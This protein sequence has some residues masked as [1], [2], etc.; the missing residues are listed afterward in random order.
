M[1]QIAQHKLTLFAV[2]VISYV[3][4]GIVPAFFAA[5]KFFGYNP[6]ALLMAFFTL[7]FV[8]WDPT[9]FTELLQYLR[10]YT[11]FRSFERWSTYVYSFVPSPI[12][13]YFRVDDERRFL[14]QFIGVF[15]LAQVVLHTF[16][17]VRCVT[18]GSAHLLVLEGSMRVFSPFHWPVEVWGYYHHDNDVLQKKFP[19]LKD[20][21]DPDSII[22]MRSDS[23]KTGLMHLNWGMEPNKPTEGDGIRVEAHCHF[24]TLLLVGF[25][26]VLISRGFKALWEPTLY[27]PTQFKHPIVSLLSS[28]MVGMCISRWLFEAYTMRREVPL[29]FTCW[30][31]FCPDIVRDDTIENIMWVLFSPYVIAMV[32]HWRLWPTLLRVEKMIKEWMEKMEA[33]KNLD[34]AAA[35]V[36]TNEIIE[37]KARAKKRGQAAGPA[38]G[39]QNPNVPP[40]PPQLVPLQY[41]A[42]NLALNQQQQQQMQL[43]FA[44]QNLMLMQQFGVAQPPVV[45]AQPVAQAQPMPQPV[46]QAQPMLPPVVQAQPQPVA[47]AQPQPQPQAPVAA[48]PRSRGSKR[49]ADT[50]AS[51]SRRSRLRSNQ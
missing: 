27:I 33:Q 31:T 36:R 25:F 34:Q 11:H 4:F 43:Q 18:T 17:G 48:A 12:A 35:T 29:P 37:E 13:Y 50:G 16:T 10:L 42:V 2:K 21:I 1:E 39:N 24:K 26:T 22:P 9:W 23:G 28:M 47:Q 49:P 40:M 8:C 19:P 32:V 14:H 41:A 45:Q 6:A 46:A 51:W 5:I 3:L 38:A 15:V 20:C 44:R 30:W 7:L